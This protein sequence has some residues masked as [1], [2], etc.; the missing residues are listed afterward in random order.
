VE[1]W[2]LPNYGIFLKKNLPVCYFFFKKYGNLKKSKICNI[3]GDKREKTIFKKK[4][5]EIGAHI[6]IIIFQYFSYKN[7]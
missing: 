3:S 4:S 5:F 7:K 6:H 1:L 2:F